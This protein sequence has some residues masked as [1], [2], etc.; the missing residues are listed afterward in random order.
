M[1]Q[2]ISVIGQIATEPK[3]F[4]PDRGVQFCSF[5]LASTE[6]RFD[7][8][9]KEWID[10]DTNWFSINAFR[11][12][13]RNAK[14][15]F[16]KG[17]RIIVMGR[18]RVRPWEK[19]DKHGTSVEIDAEGFG[20][21]VRWGTSMFTKVESG[22]AAP[23]VAEAQDLSTPPDPRMGAGMGTASHE[24]AGVD[25]QGDI[26]SAAGRLTDTLGTVAGDG[27][28]PPTTLSDDPYAQS[29]DAA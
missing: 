25:T 4:A 16:R 20:H 7:P 15:S 2:Y 1:S 27:F 11:S 23:P 18:L 21:D 10:G 8:D 17:D 26:D 24:D 28:V 22:G 29:A 13:A 12:L 3:L 6:R 14:A 5:R 9:R 19:G